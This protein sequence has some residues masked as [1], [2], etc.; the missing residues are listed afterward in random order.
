MCIDS[1]LADIQKE[2]YA[3]GIIVFNT[4][5]NNYAIVIS[6]DKG[7]DADPCSLV[8]E[9]NKKKAFVHTPPNRA[10]VPTGKFFDLEHLRDLLIEECV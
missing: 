4:N 10:L 7:S 2:R 9:F 8:L 1:L 3:K 6:G 5:N